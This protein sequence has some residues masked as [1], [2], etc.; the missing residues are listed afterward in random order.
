MF[1]HRPAA[2]RP[3]VNSGRAGFA[4]CTR[5]PVKGMQHVTFDDAFDADRKLSRSGCVAASIDPWPS[6]I[7]GTDAAL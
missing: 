3:A 2:Q 7:S 5:A 6:T 1:F 4:F